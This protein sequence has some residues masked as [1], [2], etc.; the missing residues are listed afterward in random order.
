MTTQTLGALASDQKIDKVFHIFGHSIPVGK[1]GRRMW[2]TKFKRE[3]AQQMISG[4]LS[5]RDA[6]K[7]CRVSNNTAYK[8]KN[9]FAENGTK[10]PPVAE[11]KAQVF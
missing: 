2:Q 7:T 3:M 5:V 6:Q 11:P 9:K 8:W 1:D 4:K 10:L